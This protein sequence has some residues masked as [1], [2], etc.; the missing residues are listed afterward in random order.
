[1]ASNDRK[2]DGKRFLVIVQRENWRHAARR[3]TNRIANDNKTDLLRSRDFSQPTQPTFYL[4]ASTFLLP[5]SSGTRFPSSFR[6]VYS[7]LPPPTRPCLDSGVIDW[8]AK[9]VWCWS[10]PFWFPPSPS[11]YPPTKVFFSY[12][13]ESIS[14]WLACA[15]LKDFRYGKETEKERNVF[16]CFCF[17]FFF[18]SVGRPVL[19]W[20]RW[21]TS[22]WISKRVINMTTWYIRLLPRRKYWSETFWW[23]EKSA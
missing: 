2:W 20:N 4:L 3:D 10:L 8:L 13:T 21:N 9:I 14:P 5:L 22:S 11:L 16:F 18:S 23:K 12:S 17:C 19:I 6:L 7:A 15:N 1:M